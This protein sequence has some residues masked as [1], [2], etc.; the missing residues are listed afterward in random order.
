MEK[1]G[2]PECSNGSLIAGPGI[3]ELIVEAAKVVAEDV[4]TAV[5]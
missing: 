4:V 3:E 2:N 1:K 5:A